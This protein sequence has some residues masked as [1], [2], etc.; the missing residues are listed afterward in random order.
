[1]DEL[2]KQTILLES[3]SVLSLSIIALWLGYYLTGKIGFLDRY[4]IPAAVSGG[5]VISS[6]V[7]IVYAFLDVEINFDMELR[8]ILLIAFFSTIGL[9]AKLRELLAGGK[10]LAVMLFLAVIFLFLQDAIA[11]FLADLFNVHPAY[12]LMAGSVS[13]AGGH[14]TAITWGEVFNQKFAL[15]NADVL[16]LSFATMGLVLGGIV[17]GPVARLLIKRHK[18]TPPG[19]EG[20]MEDQGSVTSEKTYLI[21]L[22]D[23]ISSIFLLAICF[24]IGT[25]THQWFE[26]MGMTFPGFLTAMFT[27]IVLINAIDILKVKIDSRPINLIGDISLQLFLGMSMISIQFWTLAG[28]FDKIAF[29]LLCQV[30]LI[31]LF[32]YF[33]VFRVIGRNYDAACISAGFVG[34]GLGATPVGIANMNAITHKYGPSPKS[35]LV[36]PLLGAFFIDIANATVIQFILSFWN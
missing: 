34:M 22:N 15:D 8:S 17:G 3:P 21:S 31:V 5:L 1:M 19:G 14:G 4:N 33:V 2:G 9:S 18:I 11:I 29:V 20:L 36:I 12:G 13:L 30:I 7:G 35:Y 25:F 26:N 24:G 16:G 27:G 23:M 6:L 28:A 32:C 10:T